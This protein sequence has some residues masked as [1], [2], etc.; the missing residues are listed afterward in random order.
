[1]LVQGKGPVKIGDAAFTAAVEDS[2]S[3]LE[4][5]KGVDKSSPRSPRATRASCPRM[6]APRS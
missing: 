4:A 5:V 1:M 3:R 2:V 6:A